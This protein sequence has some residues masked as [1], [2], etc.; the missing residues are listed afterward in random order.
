MTII[1]HWPD[2]YDNLWKYVFFFQAASSLILAIIYVALVIK[3]TR[4]P[5]SNQGNSGQSRNCLSA[6][7]IFN[8]INVFKICFKNRHNF[9][10]TIILLLIIAMLFNINTYD[11][12]LTYLYTKLKLDWSEQDFSV[13]MAI[14]M[15]T[16]AF[17]TL[18]ILTLL[19]YKFKIHDMIIGI[20][21]ASFGM[22]SRI[23][24][25]FVTKSWMM[26]LGKLLKNHIWNK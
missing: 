21:G 12:S 10:R 4:G 23:I 19:S 9:K 7:S 8:V 11:T 3:D 16:T 18:G 6:F 26:Y 2:F 17:A 24:Y 1:G 25:A 15:F 5:L 13:Y 14:S 22:F 20:L